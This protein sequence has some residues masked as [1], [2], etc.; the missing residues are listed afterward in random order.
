MKKIFSSIIILPLLGC[1]FMDSTVGPLDQDANTGVYDIQSTSTKSQNNIIKNKYDT[2]DIAK[3]ETIKEAKIE[4][5]NKK[6]EIKTNKMKKILDVPL[7]RQLPELRYG[8]EVTSTAM[9]L[10]YA[11]VEVDKMD[12]YKAIKKDHDPLVKRKGDIIKWGNPEEGFVGDMTGKNGKP[13]YAVYDK[14]IVELVNYYLPGRAINLTGAEFDT[15]LKQIEN[16]YPVVVWT[17]GDYRLPDRPE[18]WEHNGETIVTPL[19]LH[20]VV[21]VGYDDHYVYLNDPLSGKKAVKVNKKQ[22]IKS[23]KALKKRAVSYI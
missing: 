7:I 13:G 23:W 21:L 6:P 15:L 20:V 14:V 19:D 10:Q 16:G 18:K 8:C 1:N 11:G 4:K 12:L 22:F 3:K 9:M 5:T 2:K 17:T